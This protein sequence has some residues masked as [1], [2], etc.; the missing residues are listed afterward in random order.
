VARLPYA[1]TTSQ[2]EQRRVH[3]MA[4]LKKGV[5][6]AEVARQVGVT[7]GAVSQWKKAFAKKGKA[8][9]AAKPRSGRPRKLDVKILETLPALLLEGAQAHGFENDV[10]TTQRVAK[11]I[12]RKHGVRY[13]SDHVGR[14]LRQLGLSWQKPELQA[15][16]RDE[17]RIKDW[18]AKEWPRIKK[19]PSE[20]AP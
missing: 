15:K 18:V 2:K 14:L 6:P 20:S 5:K 17:K 9:L 16:D 8:G 12:E 10:W 4:L 1:L 11:L 19:K 3:A 13:N 7:R